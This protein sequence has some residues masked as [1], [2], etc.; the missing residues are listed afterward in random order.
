METLNYLRI[1][2]ELLQAVLDNP[3]E[4]MVIIDDQGIIRH[5]SRANEPLYQITASEAVGRHIRD[6]IPTSGLPEVVHSGKPHFGDTFDM[7]G[8]KVIV[9]RY[10]IKLGGKIIGAVGKMIFHDLKAFIALKH[11]IG[12]LEN[13]VRRY[14]LEIRE[15]YRARYSFADVIGKSAKLN[16]AKDAAERLAASA[17]PI[18]LIGE[19]GTGKEIFAHAI[20]QASS[21]RNH[22]FIRVN[23]ASI[24]SELFESE[25]FGYKAGAF[26]GALKS[27]KP[28]KFELAH[29]GTIFLDEVGE[30]PLGLQA[31]LLRVLQEKEIE[32]LGSPRPK[33]IDFRVIAATNRDL[34]E[35][36]RTGYFRRDLFYRLNV[37]SIQLPP[38]R[39]IKE[40]IPVLAG[41]FLMKLRR[42]MSSSVSAIAP[43][44]MAIFLAYDW[45]GNV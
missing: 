35:R 21:R 26:T 13:T 31:K 19:S 17:S 15:I 7:N 32:P 44:V 12:E 11:K 39:E 3:F 8:R 41:H 38:L 10:P 20:H 18:L 42:R 24:P 29:R 30:L 27:G 36:V 1:P 23:C 16:H 5:F 22:S 43:E 45:P 34:E 9:N 6:V 25:L 40:D 33:M 28:G 4:G 2:P 14:E 37:I